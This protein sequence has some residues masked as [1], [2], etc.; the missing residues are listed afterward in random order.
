MN[1]FDDF[2]LYENCEEYYN[3]AE[4]YEREM[5][6]EPTDEDEIVVCFTCANEISN[7][8]H[9]ACFNS[10]MSNKEIKEILEDNFDTKIYIVGI[11]F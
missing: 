11:A 5:S 2:D 7:R 9:L 4:E 8:I 6:Y 3:D 1:M 10:N